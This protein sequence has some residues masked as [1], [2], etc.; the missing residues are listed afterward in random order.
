MSLSAEVNG[1]TWVGPGYTRPALRRSLLFTLTE[2]DRLLLPL[3]TSASIS[4]CLYSF[5]RMGKPNV[6][7]LGIRDH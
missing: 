5:A 6:L 1:D 4:A 2:R 3:S 7:L